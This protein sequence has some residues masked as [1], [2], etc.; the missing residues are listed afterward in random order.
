MTTA[1]RPVQGG[2]STPPRPSSEFRKLERELARLRSVLEI[3]A[4]KTYPATYVGINEYGVKV[5]GSYDDASNYARRI[6]NGEQ[7]T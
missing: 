4:S 1:K 5:Y 7:V 3:I 6:L 2:G